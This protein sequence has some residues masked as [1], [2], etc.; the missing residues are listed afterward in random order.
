MQTTELIR[1]RFSRLYVFSYV[2]CL[3]NTESLRVVRT[4]VS[5]LFFA[6]KEK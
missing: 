5:N 4:S 2:E 6:D 3:T 1:I